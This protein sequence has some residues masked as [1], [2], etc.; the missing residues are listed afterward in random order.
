MK[1]IPMAF[2]IVLHWVDEKKTVS[3]REMEIL[4]NGNCE[5]KPEI[6][7]P[8]NMCDRHSFKLVHGKL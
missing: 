6:E 7:A 4:E 5:W 3:C 8:T 2:T 1:K